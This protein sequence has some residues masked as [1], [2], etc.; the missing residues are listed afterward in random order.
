M[1]DTYSTDDILTPSITDPSMI[2]GASAPPTVTDKP[3]FKP[4]SPQDWSIDTLPVLVGSGED[5]S[6]V[7]TGS[8]LLI[9]SREDCSMVFTGSELLI[10]S[11]ED[12]SKVLTGSE[13]LIGSFRVVLLILLGLR[14]SGLVDAVSIELL[15]S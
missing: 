12:C 2:R 5:C 7:L 11:R 15:V 4:S 8:E 6:K 3:L 10:G 9:G 13:L 1:I 14:W